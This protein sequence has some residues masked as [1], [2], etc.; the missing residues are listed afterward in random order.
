[1]ELLRT[2]S[3]ALVSVD[4]SDRCKHAKA[5]DASNN[6]KDVRFSIEEARNDVDG[7]ASSP[8]GGFAHSE[9]VVD[10]VVSSRL[11]VLSKYTDLNK[12]C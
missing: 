1:M 6:F 8:K 4:R 5:H 9:N 7:V 3:S 10:A 12:I 11:N 2:F